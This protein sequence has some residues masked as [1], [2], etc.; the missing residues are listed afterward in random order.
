MP[1]TYRLGLFLACTLVLSGCG[2]GGADNS[3]GGVLAPPAPTKYSI[4]GSVSG[5]TGT[6]LVLQIN[7]G[8]DLA[9]PSNG[10][11]SFVNVLD[12]NVS[13]T[14]T[15]KTQPSGQ[16]CNVT[17]GTGT[18]G[19]PS[20]VPASV[21][22]G[23]QVGRFLFVPNIGSNDISAYSVHTDTGALTPV[24]GSPFAAGH[25]APSLG[26]IDPAGKYFIV[27]GRG[28]AN[29]PPRVSVHAINATTGA[30]A[31]VAG[32][33]FDL[34]HNPTPPNG[35]TVATY[36]PLIHPSGAFGYTATI[37]GDR[38]YGASL[39]A[40]TGALSEIAGMPVTFGGGVGVGL[41]IYNAGGTRLYA[42]HVQGPTLGTPG[43]ISVF[44]VNAP[45]GA[46]TP[47]G[48]WPTGG[49]TPSV[50][51]L[52]ADGKVLVVANASSGTVAS[53]LVDATAG[54]LTPVAGSPVSTGASTNIV[55]NVV[56]HPG[57]PF[58]YAT[59]TQDDPT[60]SS[61]A[62]YTVDTTTGVL[63]PAGAP[64]TTSGTGAFIGA[65]D[66]SGKYFYVSN[67]TSN[68]IAAFAI[69]A[70]TGVLTAVTGSPFTAPAGASSITFDPSG[71]YLYVANS[72]AGSVSAYR[73]NPANGVL[74]LVNTVAAGTQP[75][76]GILYGLQ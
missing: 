27:T 35:A 24:A 75:S 56:W 55:T 37:P 43:Q 71:R 1:S 22:C 52:S 42:P 60:P 62:A 23:P 19:S 2:G 44:G 38:I 11:F 69:D 51:A 32:S 57:K 53:F 3:G 66:R 5:L 47:L 17:S 12:A 21:D 73:I 76:F 4:G 15:V 49:S 33:P 64:V 50:P 34:S 16:H 26:A 45:S 25:V 8:N 65:V 7:S 63:T 28:A 67:R 68:S 74:T 14:I 40:G 29:A 30:L 6:G 46:L 20:V 39:D 31:A 18:A 36:R 41:L 59:N 54:T 9:I 72:G 13:Y 61:I 10:T 70:T 48:T 58:V